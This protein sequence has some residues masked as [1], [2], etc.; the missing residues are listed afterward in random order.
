MEQNYDMTKVYELLDNGRLTEAEQEMLAMAARAR[1]EIT[2][3]ITSPADIEGL[4]A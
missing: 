2:G 3:K 1:E 4:Q